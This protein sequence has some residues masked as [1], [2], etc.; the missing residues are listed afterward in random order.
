METIIITIIVVA[1]ILIPCI[2]VFLI[3]FLEARD[4]R[5]EKRAYTELMSRYRKDS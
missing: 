5:A 3:I 1:I 2:P 4:E